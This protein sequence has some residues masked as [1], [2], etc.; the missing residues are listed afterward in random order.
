MRLEE[1]ILTNPVLEK[2]YQLFANT[3]LVADKNI[4]YENKAGL[5]KTK[6]IKFNPKY[7]Y[8][9]VS[10]AASIIV[11]LTIYLL[12]NNEKPTA[13]KFAASHRSFQ[14]IRK[15]SL[16]KTE[17]NDQQLFNKTDFS[18]RNNSNDNVPNTNAEISQMQKNESGSS[19]EI[20]MSDFR[21]GN[22]YARSNVSKNINENVASTVAVNNNN[23]NHSGS[24]FVSAKEFLFKKIRKNSSN[25]KQ[26]NPDKLNLWDVA[27]LGLKGFN[28]ITKKDLKLDRETAANGKTTNVNFVASNFEFYRT[29]KK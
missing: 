5:K 17:K 8:Y 2:E 14:H 3:K 10:V 28:R 1:F 16:N 9:P 13:E 7:I 18:N 25:K 19:V 12:F 15:T 24:D 26:D 27:D 6:I 20:A 22:L 4:V 21:S 11:L 23:Q 29:K